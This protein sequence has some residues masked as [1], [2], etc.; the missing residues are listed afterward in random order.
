MMIRMTTENAA[1]TADIE[2]I[3]QVVAA[4][5]ASQRAKDPDAFLSL[6][7]PDALWTTG[8]GKVLIGLD[9][10]SEFTRAVLPGASWDGEVSYTVTHLQFLR[11]DVA[12]VK[13]SQLYHSADGPGDEGVPTYVMTKGDDGRWLLTV[14][15]NTQVPKV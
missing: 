10:I 9:A 8:G 14:C 13:V 1:R 6:F 12:A 11:P 15:Q 5:E 7:H 4:V 2:A 3:H